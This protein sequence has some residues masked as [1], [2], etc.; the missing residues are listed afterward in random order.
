MV[1]VGP[2]KCDCECQVDDSSRV[3]VGL[4]RSIC[5]CGAR[6]WENGGGGGV[7]GMGRE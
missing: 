5:A 1:C 4:V 6:C 2:V 3:Y 7:G